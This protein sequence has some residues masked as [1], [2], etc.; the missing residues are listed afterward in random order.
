MI[1]D[2]KETVEQLHARRK[3][4][5]RR[6]RLIIAVILFLPVAYAAYIAGIGY[7]ANTSNYPETVEELNAYYTSVPLEQNAALLYEKAFG[8]SPKMTNLFNALNEG[9]QGEIL[10]DWAVPLRENVLAALANDLENNH[11]YLDLL[12]Q[13]S[14]LKQCRFSLDFTR[15]DSYHRSNIAR[16]WEP[17]KSFDFNGLS[18]AD[19]MLEYESRLGVETG[20]PNTVVAAILAATALPRVLTDIPSLEVQLVRTEHVFRCTHL[21]EYILNYTTLPDDALRSIQ[22]AIANL[23]RREAITHGLIGARCIGLACFDDPYP[24]S[25]TQLVGVFTDSL[26][27]EISPVDSDTLI[28]KGYR[29][30]GFRNMDRNAFLD[31]M[32]YAIAVSKMPYWHMLNVND[33]D[34]FVSW[35]TPV[36]QM[37][38]PRIKQ[39]VYSGTRMR[40]AP[41]LEQYFRRQIVGVAYI[42]VACTALAIERYRLTNNALPES[43]SN[44]VPDFL[45]DVLN[46]PFDGHP[47]RYKL[48]GK[49][50]VVYSIGI[51]QMDD[52]GISTATDGDITFTVQRPSPAWT[53]VHRVSEATG[54]R[55]RSGG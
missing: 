5:R 35:R 54:M 45:S 6:R 17:D 30:S 2:Q 28:N 14:T 1:P 40:L 21:L 8:L 25:G 13:A 22:I 27:D 15:S 19:M 36:C 29:W 53:Y 16:Y 11:E 9:K 47:V 24:T 51:N 41:H 44:L 10:Y 48:T 39:T 4:R 38:I 52:G 33:F 20:K 31:T 43:L 55:A 34:K 50:Y 49:G 42:Y 37:F 3:R 12:H 18:Q 26:I 7:C 32:D 23:E 46:D